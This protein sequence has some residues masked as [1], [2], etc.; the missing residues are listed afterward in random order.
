MKK[1]WFL[2]FISIMGALALAL[3]VAPGALAQCGM[4]TKQIK[5]TGW[6]PQYGGAHVIRTAEV[7]CPRKS[8]PIAAGVLS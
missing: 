8:L 6:H 2:R 4:P 7:T 1:A 3:V 5:P